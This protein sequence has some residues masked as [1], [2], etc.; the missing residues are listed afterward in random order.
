MERLWR[1]LTLAALNGPPETASARL[2]G[3]VLREIVGSG[4][5][6]SRS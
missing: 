2:L 5:P 3:A 4:A 6:A 1:P